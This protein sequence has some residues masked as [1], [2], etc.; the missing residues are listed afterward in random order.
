LVLQYV[1]SH[2]Y[3][4][5]QIEKINEFFD[6]LVERIIMYRNERKPFVIIINDVNSTYRGRD[7]FI[8]LCKKLSDADCMG[9]ILNIILIIGFKMITNA[10]E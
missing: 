7:F 9:F 10:M 8:D 2:F 3:N 1:I 6:N 4:T 5:G